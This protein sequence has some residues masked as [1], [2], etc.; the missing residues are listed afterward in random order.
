[1]LHTQL[2]NILQ[3]LELCLSCHILPVSSGALISSLA[4]APLLN[5]TNDMQ[6]NT[7]FK[8]QKLRF[9]FIK[10]PP[11]LKSVYI[12]DMGTLNVNL[13]RIEIISDQGF[14]KFAANQLVVACKNQ[15]TQNDVI[16]ITHLTRVDENTW[17][18]AL[19]C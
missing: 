19:C 11:V 9:F 4:K 7:V 3:E 18:C 5:A 13:I 17:Q 6:I 16:H 12:M 2:F 10:P 8:I 15:L 14:K 1:M